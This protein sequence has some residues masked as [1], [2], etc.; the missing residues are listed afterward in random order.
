MVGIFILGAQISVAPPGV[1]PERAMFPVGVGYVVTSMV[2]F[3][4]VPITGF[5]WWS[6]VYAV[7]I[8]VGVGVGFAT[9]L[10]SS[11]R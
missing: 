4:D 10:V 1:A 11:S 7:F 5:E 6:E 9:G 3:T 2:L 8:A